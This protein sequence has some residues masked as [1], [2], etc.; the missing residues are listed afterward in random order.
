[1]SS[2]LTLLSRLSYLKKALN[3]NIVTKQKLDMFYL[4]EVIESGE[5]AIN[6]F[7]E[8]LGFRPPDG[9][10]RAS[11]PT[12]HIHTALEECPLFYPLLPPEFVMTPVAGQMVVVMFGSLTTKGPAATG[13]WIREA[14]RGEPVEITETG[15]NAARFD[16]ETV[17][18]QEATYGRELEPQP[19]SATTQSQREFTEG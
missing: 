13:Y 1:M 18:T 9:T 14:I 11:I 12:L 6:E 3:H 5:E 10:I 2:T 16:F 19:D 15:A 4:A 17:G 7:Q 8:Q